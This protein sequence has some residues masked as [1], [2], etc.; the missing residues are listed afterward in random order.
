MH[1]I[2]FVPPVPHRLWALCRQM[3]ITD[4]VVKAAPELTGRPPPWQRDALAAVVADLAAAGLRVVALEGDPFDL[5]AV[6]L[7][8]PGRDEALER[9][10]LL[11]GNMAELGIG[12]L[13]YNFMAGT[14]WHRTGERPGRGGARATYFSLAETPRVMDGPLLETEQVWDNYASFI[15]AVM[16]EAE[17]LGLRMGLHPDDPPLPS[18][19]GMARVFGSLEAFDRAYALAPCRANGVTF[20]QANFKLMGVDLD[21]AARHFGPRIAFVHVRDVRGTAEEF[22]ELFHDEGETDPLALFRTY[23]ELCFDDVPCR[24]DHVP[25]M[26]GEGDEPGFVPGYGTLGRLFANGYLKALLTAA[27]RARPA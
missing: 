7:G 8:L 3:G 22:V 13:C 17:R 25:A 14:G 1:L 21:A 4:V 16:P 24:C 18:L 2:E 23:R 11:L 12:L 9:Y 20:C 27:G 19:G 6:K 26:E 5:S 15:R 10:R